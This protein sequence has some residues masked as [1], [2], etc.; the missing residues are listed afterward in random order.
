MA[1]D[2]ALLIKQKKALQGIALELIESG[3]CSSVAEGQNIAESCSVHCYR[4][5]SD[6][7]R[8]DICIEMPNGYNCHTISKVSSLITKPPRPHIEPKVLCE[9]SQCDMSERTPPP[10]QPKSL[11]TK[12]AVAEE[13]HQ[14]CTSGRGSSCYCNSGRTRAI[15]R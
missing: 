12:E 8:V 1:A 5:P 2:D 9:S 3:I 15:L 11:P 6:S 4:R 10:P 7:K 13:A 14:V